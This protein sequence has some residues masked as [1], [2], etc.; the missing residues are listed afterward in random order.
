[1]GDMMKGDFSR[2]SFDRKKHYTGVL[3]QQGRVDLD[4]DWNEA[5]EIQEYLRRT[6]ARDVIG[7]C[8]LPKTGGG[9]G[10][11]GVNTQNGLDLTISSG[12]MYVDGILCELDADTTYLGQVDWP[13]PIPSVLAPGKRYLVY[14]DVWKR[15]VTAIED[16]DILEPALG[17]PDTTTRLKTICQV[18]VKEV[19]ADADCESEL[20]DWP[21]APSRGLLTTQ[22]TPSVE[23]ED[24]CLIP[25]GGGYRGLENRLYRVEIH[26]VDESG[27]ATFKW[28]K[29]NGSVAFP[30]VAFV[31]GEPN[32]VK[33]KRL[34]KDQ[35]LALRVGDWAEVSDDE[36]E[37]TGQAG[38]LARI[39]IIDA[40]P[41]DSGWIL[42]L[43]TGQDLSLYN[44]GRHPKVRRWDQGGDAIPVT[45]GI[46][47]S[48]GDGVEILF[49]GDNFRIG[50]Y[51]VFCARTAT[52]D[53]ERLTDAP[54]VGV[55]HHYCRLALVSWHENAAGG[56]TFDMTDCRNVFPPLTDL[57]PYGCCIR[58]EPG[59]DVQRIVDAAIADGGGC[60]CLAK[61][62]HDVRG[63]LL[64]SNARNLTIS[65]ENT[66]TALRLR[67]TS[68]DALGGIVLLNGA[69]VSIKS[70]FVIGTDVQAVIDV[71]SEANRRPGY[72]LSLQNLTIVNSTP[73]RERTHTLTCGLRMSHSEEV[74]VR[75]CRVLAENGIVCL[76]G[77]RLPKVPQ[78]PET[79]KGVRVEETIDFEDLP[80]GA[81]YGVGET[82]SSS[83]AT[84]RAL[85]LVLADGTVIEDGFAEVEVG[86]MA[87][88]S[89]QEVVLTNLNL[90]L[91]SGS[92]LRG[93][94][95][96]FAHLPENLENL[97]IEVNGES[98]NFRDFEEID[99]ETI[100][101]VDIAAESLGMVSYMMGTLTLTGTIDTFAVGGQ[102]FW[103]DDVTLVP[104]SSLEERFGTGIR[105]LHMQGVRVRYSTFGVWAMTSEDWVLEGCDIRAIATPRKGMKARGK[106]PTSVAEESSF[107]NEIEPT[108]IVESGEPADF[109]HLLRNP[110]PA[111]ADVMRL[112]KQVDLLMCE[113]G[114]TD[115]GTTIKA[116]MWRDCIVSNCHL[117]GA[118][119]M[120][121]GWWDGGII[122]NNI[123]RAR[124]SGLRA[125][126]LQDAW[127]RENRI[128]CVDGPGFSFVGSLHSRI[129]A[130]CVRGRLG[131][132][133]LELAGAVRAFTEYLREVAR[134][135]L[136]QDADAPKQTE[137]A[138]QLVLWMML[139]ETTRVFGLE[140][141]IDKVQQVIDALGLDHYP[142]LYVAS[143]YLHRALAN[144]DL[145]VRLP[146]PIIALVLDGNDI[147]GK[148]GCVLLEDFVTLGGM[149]VA[150]NRFHTVQGQAL[151][152]NTHPFAA[153]VHLII[154]LWRALV[155]LLQEQLLSVLGRVKVPER[156]R[157]SLEGLSNAL[158]SSIEEWA[159]QSEVFLEADYRV[160][161][162]S[163]RS[164][165][166]AIESNIFELTV[167][168]NHITL[169]ERPI[170]NQEIA[171]IAAVFMEKEVTAPFAFAILEG[172][173]W[174]LRRASEG[175]MA[176]E[177]WLSEAEKRKETS[178]I[179]CRAGSGISH[180][181]MVEATSNLD[182]SI[183]TQD[184]GGVRRWL[185]KLVGYLQD[186]VSG[187]GIWMKG[188]GCRIVD[189]Q[190]LVPADVDSDTWARGGILVWADPDD[191]AE[192][193]LLLGLLLGR[194]IDPLLGMTETLIDNNEVIGG[195]GHGIDI[196]ETFVVADLKV[197]D[198]QIR[199]MAGA[200]VSID[201]GT[202][203]VRVDIEENHIVDCCSKPDLTSLTDV[204]GGV[205]VR[206]A[207]LLRI[208]GNRISQCGRG[209]SEYGVFGIDIVGVYGL[210]LADNHIMCN[211]GDD[212][213]EENGGVRLCETFGEAD[214]HDNK[215][216]NNRGVGLLWND[217]ISLSEYL[218]PQYVFYYFPLLAANTDYYSPASNPAVGNPA[219][220]MVSVPLPQPLMALLATLEPGIA[221]SPEVRASVCGNRL[222]SSVD[223]DFFV[224][225]LSSLDKLVFSSNSCH[226]QSEIYPLGPIWEITRKVLFTSNL[227]QT[228]RLDVPSVDIRASDKGGGIIL[229]N[230][231]SARIDHSPNVS[232]DIHNLT[233]EEST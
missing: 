125:F 9:F 81:T 118:R 215:I 145:E 213:P 60:L 64:L 97:N 88:G 223:S 122:V 117:Q 222:E 21:P 151:R 166:T 75:D 148:D 211:G 42:T 206:H 71:R 190:I 110:S 51:W 93:L 191:G 126:W 79:R 18:K 106:S 233:L 55:Q 227:L 114:G 197:R 156:A 179:M 44:R 218:A 66:A 232:D 86:T 163:V 70:L 94:S 62:V 3:K 105:G 196:H 168:D 65:G 158:K 56:L 103:M 171:Y 220:A 186:F 184:I 108:V 230:V 157:D 138:E 150:H 61:G 177:S 89:G 139:E 10:I 141:L 13:N 59:D 167:L 100:G 78:V 83:G 229:G 200:G 212:R 164:L 95:L 216:L 129:E 74:K 52:G 58:V 31:A 121:V 226:S 180:V 231:S 48:L 112:L 29:D 109:D 119:G 188:A 127:W 185:P 133:N 193:L 91:D 27:E 1:M 85:P 172:S 4:A 154:L 116:F 30:V 22:V 24:P 147:E 217:P 228:A 50:D 76:N 204:K 67:G 77:S 57:A 6:R 132:V 98:R 160:E 80:P 43:D 144:P 111:E 68:E 214:V 142:A 11:G 205:V 199:G 225:S 101:G 8:G 140:N 82:F 137:T 115:M 16:P 46:P 174:R 183:K 73:T 7:I 26:N 54:P 72:A 149:K 123:V 87:G 32:K 169:H 176:D 194:R 38:T 128:S 102:R 182:H 155:K 143:V 203:A 49:S 161:S 63:P 195:V 219:P 113:D 35:V 90:G 201:E 14:L 36:S 181:G 173:P 99:G 25:M 207:A 69:H 153:N 12:R 131:L 170:S 192:I 39:A 17:G 224:F 208:R 146:M 23:E 175:L 189:N 162:N 53:V 178:D 134:F 41:D 202:L 28:S 221:V 165:H 187:H 120:D 209:Q 84:F 47:I 159:R 135:Y 210:T 33:V 107:S 92:A 34:G 198:N 96:R 20:A 19:S 40:A 124:Y 152:I 5:V 45:L 15:H 104:D 37:L 2:R 136:V 130:N